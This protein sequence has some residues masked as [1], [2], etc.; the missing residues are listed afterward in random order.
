MYRMRFLWLS[1]VVLASLAAASS[2]TRAALRRL[3]QRATV[4][5]HPLSPL[6]SQRLLCLW[7]R[8]P[9]RQGTFQGARSLF[10]FAR[11]FARPGSPGGAEGD[12]RGAVVLQ[13]FVVA[14]TARASTTSPAIMAGSGR[15]TL[16]ST[17]CSGQGWNR[18]L[19]PAGP[20]RTKTS[21]GCAAIRAGRQWPTTCN[22]ATPT[23]PPATTTKSRPHPARGLRQGPAHPRPGGVARHGVVR[24]R[25]RR[26]ILSALRQRTG[27][28]LRRHQRHLAAV[29]GRS[30]GRRTPPATRLAST[31]C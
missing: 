22:A 7:R 29:R 12:Y 10:C 26:Q 9:A 27:R 24:G 2:R 6:P 31:P 13:H 25:F 18:A 21:K 28:G 11:G 3:R 1:A 19:T 15:R 23:G 16:P 14:R 17:G 20:A 30:S 8:P 5:A 4:R